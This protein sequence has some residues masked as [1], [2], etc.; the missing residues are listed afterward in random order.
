MHGQSDL[1][2]SL[3]MRRKPVQGFK[4]V[5]VPALT[6]FKGDLSLD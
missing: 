4:G 6:P 1:Q 3:E 2:S 5:L